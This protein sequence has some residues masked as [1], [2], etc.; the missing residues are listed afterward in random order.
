MLKRQPPR[1]R[2]IPLQSLTIQQHRLHLLPGTNWKPNLAACLVRRRSCRCRARS[3][4]AANVLSSY[5]CRVVRRHWETCASLGPPQSAACEQ[6]GYSHLGL[7]S[8]QRRRCDTAASADRSAAHF[9][10]ACDDLWAWTKPSGR[11]EDCR[12]GPG[13]AARS[14]YHKQRSI[15]DT[16]DRLAG[17]AAE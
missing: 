2:I 9:G 11:R 1:L 3:S 13:V 4:I 12:E 8:G 10:E 7:R 15:V 6:S 5:G 16:G 14:R 17:T